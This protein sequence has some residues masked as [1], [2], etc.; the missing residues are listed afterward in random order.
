MLSTLARA[1]IVSTVEKGTGVP[2][3]GPLST[4]LL[5]TGAALSTMR[6]RRAVGF[7]L[8]AVGGIIR[9]QETVRPEKPA[10]PALPAPSRR[11]A[12]SAT[13]SR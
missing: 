6:G 3:A 13:G 1:A 11:E 7:A 12:S 5:T 4:V 8:L 9:W 10:Q 2:P